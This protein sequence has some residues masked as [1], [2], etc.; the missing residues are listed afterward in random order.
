MEWSFALARVL[1]QRSYLADLGIHA[2]GGNYERTSAVG[3]EA[4]GVDHVFAVGELEVVCKDIG[5]L[6]DIE[7]FAR[8]RRLVG[9]NRCALDKSAVCGNA[10]ARLDKHNIADGYFLRGDYHFFAAAQHLSAGGVELFE[11]IEALFRL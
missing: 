9:L 2:D 7:R 6:I 4:A 5:G 10:I 11:V 8:K 1:Y 3:D